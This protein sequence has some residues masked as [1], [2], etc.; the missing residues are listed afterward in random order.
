MRAQRLRCGRPLASQPEIRW[1]PSPRRRSLRRLPGFDPTFR[2]IRD[3]V[4]FIVVAAL[5][6]TAISATIGVSTLCAAAVQPWTRFSDLWSDGWLGDVVGA[7]VIAPVIPTTTRLPAAVGLRILF[8]WPSAP[9]RN[10]NPLSTSTTGTAN[11]FERRLPVTPTPLHRLT[12][13]DEDAV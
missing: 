3:V 2:R 7:L 12:P 5:M 13:G 11:G 10:P 8:A 1:R 4:A 9:R 6:S